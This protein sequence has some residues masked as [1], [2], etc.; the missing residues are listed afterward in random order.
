MGDSDGIP[1]R[2]AL[3]SV[4]DKTGLVDFASALAERGVALVASGGTARALAD[5]GLDASDVSD[6]TGYPEMMDGRVKTLHPAV[7]GGIL[8]RRDLAAHRDAMEANGIAPIDLVVVNLYPFEETI[9]GGAERDEAVEQIDIGGPAL[10]R[11]AAKNHA[12]VVVATDPE[13]YGGIL[14]E[15]AE[16]DGGTTLDFRKC[17]AAAA[18]ARTASY[19]AAIS[20]WFARDVD[21]PFPRHI[22]FGGT[23]AEVLRY[24][25]NPHQ[26]AAFYRALPERPGA[27]SATPIQGKALSYNNIGDADAAFELVA[28][29]DR[30]AI[31]IIKHANPCGVAV[32][33]TLAEA[34][35]RAFACDPVSAF[36]GVVAA[37]RGID[38]AAAGAITEIFVEVVIAPSIDEDALAV[39]AKKPNIRLLTTGAVP[40]TAAPGLAIRSI[41]GGM[42]V[43]DRDAASQD[44]VGL[45]VVTKRA[46]TDRE[47]RDLLFA[48]TV[49]KHVK[50][51]AIVF[52]R[53]GATAGI[54]AG[55]MSRV[56]STRIAAIKAADVASEAGK[57]EPATTG[58]VAASDA[59]L[60]FADGLIA[61]ADAGATAMIQPG[62]SIRDDEVIAAA[63]ERNIAMVLTGRRHFRH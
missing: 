56:D 28:E 11:A 26:E 18:Y 3:F 40:E 50:S 10:I 5:A 33:D 25:E 21:I 22:A 41:A 57:A 63:D 31:A 30:P 1:V 14:R 62:G 49:A 45:R 24:G 43:Q 48:F 20:Q 36:G 8:A 52:A 35:A 16:N 61:A 19:D 15:L 47:R 13:D 54:G 55:Q 17:L 34:Y 53:D 9:A 60:P 37:N 39:F 46:P 32:S 23:R 44:A 29:F 12:F 4:S 42:L 58:S 7:H 2:R 6:L 27:A 59:F 51:N 38:A